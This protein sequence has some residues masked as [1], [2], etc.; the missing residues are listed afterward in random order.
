MFRTVFLKEKE[1]W[2]PL[3]IASAALGLALYQT[4]KRQHPSPTS[5]TKPSQT[6]GKPCQDSKA[7]PRL[8]VMTP[9]ER[10]YHERFMRE[11]IAMV[12]YSPCLT[13]L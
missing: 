13:S 9:E 7:D 6:D 12:N 3:L 5:A 10:A 4:L 11:A 8:N 2:T 1:L